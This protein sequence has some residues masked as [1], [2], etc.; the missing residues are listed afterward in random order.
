MNTETTSTTAKPSVCYDFSGGYLAS[1]GYA[2]SSGMSAASMGLLA[3]ACSR[4]GVILNDGRRVAAAT[5][6]ACNVQ[7][8]S[9]PAGTTIAIAG[10]AQFVA[11]RAAAATYII[12]GGEQ[13]TGLILNA[14][15]TMT[16]LSG[17]VASGTTITS[18]GTQNVL[19]GGT[20]N[21]TTLIDKGKQIVL[22]GGMAS[23]CTLRGVN[24]NTRGYQEIFSG[25]TAVGTVCY[26]Y[27]NQTVTGGMAQDT[28]ISS[29]GIQAI[30]N[31]GISLNAKVTSGGTQSATEGGLLAGKQIVE[32]SASASGGT[33]TEMT[34]NGSAVKGEQSVLSG[35][36]ANNITV[37]GGGTLS[38]LSGGTANGATLAGGALRLASGAIASGAVGGHGS[39]AA[40]TD[41]TFAS[42]DSSSVIPLDDA[43]NHFS[44]FTISGGVLKTPNGFQVNSGGAITVNSGGTLQTDG[45]VAVASGGI[46]AVSG[47]GGI[48]LAGGINANVPLAFDNVSGSVGPVAANS[49]SFAGRS[50]LSASAAGTGPALSAAG[51]IDIGGELLILAP[52][53]GSVGAYGGGYAILDANGAPAREVVIGLDPASVSNVVARQRWPWNGLVDI[54]YT[55]GGNTNLLAELKARISF[56]APDGRSWVATKF[57]PGAEPSVEPG[58]HRATWDTKA[59]G[60]TNVVADGVVATVELVRQPPP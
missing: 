45:A 13:S 11:I 3:R 21:S 8:V 54:D 35:G 40:C 56:A 59:D 12:T 34:V 26:A 44:S 55:I 2:L 23:G 43:I 52:A 24:T 42:V 58:R 15:D 33:L 50:L 1:S 6:L 22:S 53:G 32:T 25:G 39:V 38:F 10:G 16:V 14:G 57:L 17:G 7:T 31:G 20:A 9:L 5:I 29:G 48:L 49:I 27:G 46:F 60:A 30:T 28:T 47:G 51:G 36:T 19:S 41:D 4:G 37:S 18:G